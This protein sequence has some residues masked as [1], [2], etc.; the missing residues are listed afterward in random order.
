MT[1]ALQS[2]ATNVS[3]GHEGGGDGL[4]AVRVDE[5]IIG[6]QLL[7]PIY[8][9]SGVLLLAAGSTITSDFKRLLRQHQA[10]TVRM[11]A[12][13]ASRASLRSVAVEAAG[14][15]A[16]DL[17]VATQLERVFDSGLL[18]VRNTGPALKES[19]AVHGST[20]YDAQQARALQRQRAAASASLGDMMKEAVRGKEI[21]GSVVTR[22]AAAQMADIA[23]DADC[24]LAVVLDLSREQALADHCVRMATLGMAIGTEIGL[25]AE[26]CKRLC[27]AGLV[28]DWGMA[29]VPA[30]IRNAPRRLS[31]FE[32][33]EVMKHPVYTAEIL[34]RMPGT[35]SIVPV[36]SYQVHE[37]MNGLGYPRGR[38]GE[39]IHLFARIL[40]VADTYTALT[41]PRPH[42][43][44]IAPYSAMECLI[45]LANS[46]ELDPVIVRALLHVL[47]LFPIGSYVALS[48][49]SVARVLRRNGDHYAAP[50]VQIVQDGGGN[51]V[52]TDAAEA[53]VDVA[54]SE[55]T[56]VQ[57]LPTPGRSEV[58]LTA[59]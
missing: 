23:R 5:L 24:L 41:E 53:V 9:D 34:E 54:H 17:A 33:Y 26:N 43:P 4:E 46:R 49:G 50:I 51:P 1:A 22:L 52:P 48:D 32:F 57:A 39:R 45:K 29:R 13:D 42:R 55:L 6:R 30:A 44:A 20:G 27:V 59:D 25:D 15:M 7:H 10:V 8:D 38:T 58:L 56:V 37:R 18:Q 40:G 21:S 2:D 12:T 35:P 3:G 19:L 28:H 47:G 36:V 14:G 11:S 16:L 31:R